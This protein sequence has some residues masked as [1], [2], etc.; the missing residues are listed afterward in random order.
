MSAAGSGFRAAGR[1]AVVVVIAVLGA[2]AVLAKERFYSIA[3]NSPVRER[4]GESAKSGAAGYLVQVGP[5]S[6]P[7][8]ADR[9]QLVVRDGPHDLRLLEQHRWAGALANDIGRALAD[10]LDPLLA[11]GIA[12]PYETGQATFREPDVVFAVAVLRFDSIVAP[13][14]QVDDEIAWSVRCRRGAP[15]E[16]DGVRALR[17][18]VKEP[19]GEAVG[20]RAL[21]AAHADVLKQVARDAAPA[22]ETLGTQC[23]AARADAPLH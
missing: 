1:V 12:I 18:G 20:Y 17:L 23:A 5:V 2:C 22:I 4:S 14:A 9:S 15:L 16:R 7:E 3:S 11:H 21:V 8:Q 13:S 10:A 6:V 19:V